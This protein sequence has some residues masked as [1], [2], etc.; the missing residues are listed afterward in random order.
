M[1]LNIQTILPLMKIPYRNPPFLIDILGGI[2]GIIFEILFFSIN[3]SLAPGFVA[4]SEKIKSV[5]FKGD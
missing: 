4:F 2:S 1:I 5:E 3:I